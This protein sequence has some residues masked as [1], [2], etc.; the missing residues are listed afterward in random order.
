MFSIASIHKKFLSG[1]LFASLLA[2]GVG[3]DAAPSSAKEAKPAPS[4]ETEK[5]MELDAYKTLEQET[6]RS[7]E[8]A[9]LAIE[10]M[11]WVSA[12]D[13][14]KAALS[15]L[16]YHYVV[17]DTIDDSGMK[18]VLADDQERTHKVESAAQIR[19]RVLESR[20]ASLQKKIA[21]L[22]AAK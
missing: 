12:N 4:Q 7:L 16:N 8:E 19:H 13:L 14:L 2:C 6:S 1:C 20:L 11:Q 3:Q 18:L 5:S 15:K 9:T 10:K 17:L 22:Q 21:G